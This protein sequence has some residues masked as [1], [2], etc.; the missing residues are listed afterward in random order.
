MKKAASVLYL[1]CAILSVA[2]VGLY[3]WL[4]IG[5]LTNTLPAWL[6]SA[7]KNTFPIIENDSVI[8]YSIWCG[9]GVLHA[10][11]ACLCLF[12]RA[13]VLNNKPYFGLYVVLI[14]FAIIEGFDILMLL[15]SIFALISISEPVQQP[16]QVDEK[17]VEETKE[18]NK[19]E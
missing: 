8:Y 18:E 2:F 12:A 14:I 1:I 4:G 11:G 3:L 19:I 9:F 6:D 7:I 15:A 10:T 17:Q 5:G 13:C 16:A